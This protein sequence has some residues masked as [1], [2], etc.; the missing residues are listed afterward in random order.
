VAGAVLRGRGA[1][2]PVRGL[3]PMPPEIAGARTVP[4]W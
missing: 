1:C 3:P 2:P 4:G